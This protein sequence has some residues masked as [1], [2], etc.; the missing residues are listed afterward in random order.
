MYITYIFKK[1]KFKKIYFCSI[2]GLLFVGRTLA[3]QG[4]T[5]PNVNEV[6]IEEEMEQKDTESY[7]EEFCQYE[8]KKII[9]RKEQFVDG[10]ILNTL[11]EC[12]DGVCD[13]SKVPENVG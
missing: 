7:Y 6:S 10:T 2:I 12:A 4:N 8:D 9:K 1:Y 3:E 5:L 11:Y 13:I